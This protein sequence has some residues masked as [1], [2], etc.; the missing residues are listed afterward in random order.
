MIIS[1]N[2]LKTIS[3]SKDLF[4]EKYIDNIPEIQLSEPFRQG[5]EIH[6]LANYYLKGQDISKLENALSP[7]RRKLWEKLK[8][9]PYF[10]FECINSEYTVT[11]KL[12]EFWIGGRIDALVKNGKDYYILDYKTGQIPE[13][14]VYDYQTMVY[15]YTLDKLIKN[16]DSLNFVYL[17][18]KTSTEEKITLNK[19]LLKEYE[20]KLLNGCLQIKNL[21]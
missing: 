11:S 18:L 20:K 8:T 1:P 19:D 15:L 9:N 2:M 12:G 21:L 13:N 6:A 14:A 5:K 10:N 17:G 3:K 16:Y 7:E 4:I